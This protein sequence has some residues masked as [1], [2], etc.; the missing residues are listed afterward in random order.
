METRSAPAGIQSDPDSS[1]IMAVVVMPSPPDAP[2]AGNIDISEFLSDLGKNKKGKSDSSF[3][4]IGVHVAR[5][6]DAILAFFTCL[7]DPDLE[8]LA[9][10]LNMSTQASV[11]YILYFHQ[12]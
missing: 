7:D 1:I 6:S 2:E 8:E 11:S 10:K 5:E 4:G 12:S 9:Q 3:S